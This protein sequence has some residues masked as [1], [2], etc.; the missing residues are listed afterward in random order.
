[1]SEDDLSWRLNNVFSPSAPI[2][3]KELFSG[4]YRQLEKACDAI[5]ERG[6]HFI[7]YGE[8]GVGKTSLANII[9]TRFQ[10]VTISKITCNR[11]D[12]FKDLWKKALSRINFIDEKD[13]IGFIPKK[14]EEP[15]QLDW[16]LPDTTEIS[17]IDLQKV[18]ENVTRHLVFIFDEF[19][20][21]L[22]DEV[23]KSFAD[24][25][26]SLSDNSSHV[27]IGIV[28]IGR[29]V[30]DL[31]GEHKSLD[32]CFMQIKMPRM[33]K[34]EL[35][36]IIVKGL[37][38]LDMTID[39]NVRERI[40][41]FS[42]G[43]PHYTHLIAKFCA[44]NCIIL[45]DRHINKEHYKQAI[46]EAIENSN[47]SIMSSY[48]DAITSSKPKS[49]FEIIVTACALVDEDEFGTFCTRDLLDPYFRLTG[50]KV[51]VKDLSYNLKALCD[52]KKR[53][54]FLVKTN[55]SSNAR[56]RLN[57]PLMKIFLKMKLSQDGYYEQKGLFK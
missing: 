53:G 49:K 19:D 27:T 28:G 9:N 51:E 17:S 50:K 24:T 11:N 52:N 45:G 34:D 39:E 43:F 31:I 36:K 46:D 47:Q 41:D 32:R 20:S 8:R 35:R 26:K 56:Y 6:Q 3:S 33:S 40:V 1:M 4:R 29:N 7:I 14:I 16:M 18:F 48:Q 30:N 21:I 15:Y 25:I 57:N 13:G 5:N 2:T 54:G 37:E 55:K 23:K 12:L 44:K 22:S 10:N 38:V 42:S